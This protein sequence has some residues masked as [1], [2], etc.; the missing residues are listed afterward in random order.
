L[1]LKP[2]TKKPT[3]LVEY[4]LIKFWTRVQSLHLHI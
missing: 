2:G 4:I 1:A 3:K